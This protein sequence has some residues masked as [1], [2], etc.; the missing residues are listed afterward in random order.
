[1][2]PIDGTLDVWNVR[3][4][5]CELANNETTEGNKTVYVNNNERQKNVLIHICLVYHN[6][7]EVLTAKKNQ[8]YPLEP[9]VNNL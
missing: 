4:P 3:A 8:R 5:T 6:N 2:S 9:C 1:M 7:V